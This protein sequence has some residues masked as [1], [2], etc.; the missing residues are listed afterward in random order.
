MPNPKTLI[1]GAGP[2]GLATAM[3]LY[4]AKE[5]FLV[6]EK[7]SS[8]GGLAQTYIFKED[9]LIFRTDNGPHRFFSK[10][11][12]LY[13]F[14]ENLLKEH[15]IEVK[16]QTRQFIQGKFYEY[17]IK[18]LQALKNIGLF[19]ACLIILD[20]LRAIV[21]YR[22]FGKKIENFEDYIV[23][24]FGKRL[25]AFNMINYSE[26]IWGI[27]ANTIHVSWAKQRIKGLSI[28]SLFVA[29]FKAIFKKRGEN[30]RSLID[31]FYYPEYGTGLIYE[32]IKEKIEK[33]HPIL[34]N[35][36]PVKIKHLNNKITEV[37]TSNKETYSPEY[38]VE[39]IPIK[40]FLHLLDP[41]PPR[42]VMEAAQKMKYRNQ[43]YL[44]ITLDKEKIT[45][46]QWI[47]FPDKN[48]PFARVSEMKNFSKQ[49]SPK[50]KTSL[51][52]EF[53]CSEGD[54][55][56]NMSKENLFNLTMDHMEKMKFFTR[57]EVRAYYHLKKEK[58]YPVYD[59]D[60]QEYLKTVQDYLDGFTNL[61][62]IGRPGRFRYNNQDH[63]LEMG[64]LAAKSIIEKKRYNIEAVGSSQEYYEK[65][66]IAK[67]EK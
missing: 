55:L 1:V 4:K 42:E 60:Y 6:I 30:P 37:I 11:P 56:W 27:P 15:W 45:S 12:Y 28:R 23:A 9:D 59:L 20:Y 41:V 63:S 13:E 34:L 35:T 47:Y 21:I 22:M 46:D 31:V 43:V 38:L 3:E 17:P 62:Y 5:D 54:T 19:N 32:T 52:V 48:V 39:S 66:F 14:I 10:N 49:M 64:I 24:H 51:F 53:F 2:A 16:R 50:G 57:K 7:Q 61:F 33:E 25:G 26:K 29:F 67:T 44:F 18:P 8:V 40:S 36:E 65:G 58:V